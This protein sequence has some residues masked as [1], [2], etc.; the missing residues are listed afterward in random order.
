MFPL[1]TGEIVFKT[2]KI[3][4]ALQLSTIIWKLVMGSFHKLNNKQGYDEAIFPEGL[5]PQTTISN[6][7]FSSNTLKFSVNTAT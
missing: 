1:A 5:V 7:C 4:N 2:A 6:D 3:S